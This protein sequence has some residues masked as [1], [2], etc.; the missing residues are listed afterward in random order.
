[1]FTYYTRVEVGAGALVD[2]DNGRIHRYDRL[3][4]MQKAWR[5]WNQQQEVIDA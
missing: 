5:E 4:S 3:R 1:M 2:I